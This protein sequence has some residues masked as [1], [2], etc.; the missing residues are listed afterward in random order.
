MREFEFLPDWYSLLRRRRR[1]LMFHAWIT[2]MVVAA[3]IM[4]I[5]FSQ[6]TVVAAQDALQLL[7]DRKDQTNQQL[8]DLAKSREETASLTDQATAMRQLGP[9]ISVGRT[10]NELQDVM[11]AEIDLLDLSIAAGGEDSLK[12]QLHGVAPSD[13][14]VGEFI[15]RLLAS[16]QFTGTSMDYLRDRKQDGRLMREF[17]ITFTIRGQPDQERP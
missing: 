16:P 13:A 14:T 8:M 9:P 11:P 5:F 4:W 3:A 1:V 15:S 12:I 6:N 7:R 17:E 10:L 2:G